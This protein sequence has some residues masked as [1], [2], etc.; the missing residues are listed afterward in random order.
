MTRIIYILVIASLIGNE[1]DF[2]DYYFGGWPFNPDKDKIIGSELIPDCSKD[3]KE[4]LC[5]CSSHDD[6]ETNMCFVSPRVGGYCV[7]GPQTVFPEFIL[8]DQFGEE[9]N[10]YDFA[11]QGK[12]IIVEF[13][14][15]WC[16]PCRDLADWMSNGNPGVTSSRM[17]KKEYNFIKD[18][19]KQDAVYFINIIMQ[20]DYKTPASLETL[21]DWFQMYPD[22][23]VL[24][25]ADSNEDVLNWV[26]PTGYPTIILLNDKMET[27][28]FSVR[29][30][31]DTFNYLSSLYSQD[32]NK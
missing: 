29:G 12:L 9:V 18:L 21:E 10:I 25:L 20:D 27:I 23:H 3:K 26:R 17:W 16:K 19:V 13:S 7:P 8:K 28:M 31:H 24:L 4:V 1:Q 5:A 30:W 11:G 32:Q 2:S 14:T 15:S 6:C 22:D